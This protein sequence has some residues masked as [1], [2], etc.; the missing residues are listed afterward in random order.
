[1][2]T[3][4]V[5]ADLL[6]IVVGAFSTSW[7]VSSAGLRTL[8]ALVG[9]GALVAGMGLTVFV[10][11]TRPDKRWFGARAVAESV[12]TIA[13]RYMTGAEPY[14][15]SLSES[16]ADDRFVRELRG[17]LRGR[18][19]IAGALAGAEAA[20]EQITGT[21]RD[22]RSAEVEHRKSVYL[23]DR[24]H[25]QRTWYGDRATKSARSSTGWLV[26]VG[27]SQLAA[28]T[29]AIALV[30]WPSLELNVSSVFAALAAA[31]MAWLQVKQHQESAHAYALAAHEL[32]LVEAGAPHVVTEEE[33]S[34][35][36]GD[37]ENAI[38]REHTLWVARR[39]R[40]P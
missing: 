10:L 38:S 12:K 37:A 39:D 27:A 18:S 26:A 8:L 11:Q 31:F 2:Y 3:S 14:Q 36:V 19:E 32:G 22:I 28:A 7:A 25:D 16:E 4:L 13:W 6:L 21:M 33:L 9:A 17:I 35:F 23:S 34:S 29:A 5:C 20:T 1:M 15:K 24:V 30:R 40:V